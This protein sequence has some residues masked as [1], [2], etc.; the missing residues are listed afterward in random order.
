MK[1]R[2]GL[3]AEAEAAV[4]ATRMKPPF[5]AY[6]PSWACGLAGLFLLCS[7]QAGAAIL[8]EERADAMY[9]SYDGGGVTIDGPSFL[10]RKNFAETVSASANYYVDNVTSASI[11]VITSGASE[12]GEKRTEFSVGG[13]Y[14]V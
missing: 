12:Y 1:E 8:P 9:H 13:D 6:P 2:A 4:A 10:V 7:V 5:P 11:D 3:K 14:F